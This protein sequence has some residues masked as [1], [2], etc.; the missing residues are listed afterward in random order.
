MADAGQWVEEMKWRTLAPVASFLQAVVMGMAGGPRVTA[1][2]CRVGTPEWIP[3]ELH[4][5]SF[6]GGSI[7]GQVDGREENLG[8]SFKTSMMYIHYRLASEH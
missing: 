7:S 6:L 5:D 1:W 4:A 2:C 8:L 3:C